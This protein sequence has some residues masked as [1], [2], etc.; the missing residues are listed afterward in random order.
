MVDAQVIKQRVEFYAGSA[1]VEDHNI[2]A[3]I[4]V[5]DLMLENPQIKV[6][7]TSK[8]PAALDKFVTCA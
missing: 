8:L 1:V 7:A 2:P 3:L 4:C 5:A 6:G